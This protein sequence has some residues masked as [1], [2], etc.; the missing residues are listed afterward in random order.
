[1]TNDQCSMAKEIQMS[2]SQWHARTSARARSAPASGAA[3]FALASVRVSSA[4]IGCPGLAA[5]GGGRAPAFA[6]V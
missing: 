5:A 6:R 1:M 2:K 4:V 3:T